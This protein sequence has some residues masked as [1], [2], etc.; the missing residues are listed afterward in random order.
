M[1][2]KEMYGIDGRFLVSI[3]NYL[4]G[5]EQSVVIEN[6]VSLSKPLLSGVPRGS[7]LGPILFV[8]FINDLPSGLTSGTDIALYADNTKIWRSC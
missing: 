6:C 5:R 3:K 4:Q 8:L 7:I 1:K 2:L